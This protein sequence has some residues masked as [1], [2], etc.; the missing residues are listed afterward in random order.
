MRLTRAV[1]L[2]AALA[3]PGLAAARL[4]DGG[5]DP[6]RVVRDAHAALRAGRHA[7]A[8][9]RYIEAA[10]GVPDIS[11]W[12]LRRAALLTPD[13]AGRAALYSQIR[14]PIVRARLLETEALARERNGDHRGAAIRYDS[15][16]RLVDATR[17]RLL[18]APGKE[19]RRG[20]RLGLVTYIDRYAGSLQAQAAIDLLLSTDLELT[21]ED[22]LTVARA[23]ARARLAAQ[24]V[25]LYPR[26]IA[27]GL[28]TPQ[29]RIAYGLA[30][31]QLGRHRDAIAAF[32]KVPADAPPAREA[33]YQRAVSLSR[34]GLGDS[35]VAVLRRVAITEDSDDVVAPK[36]LFLIGDIRWR[37]GDT[38][39]ARASWREQVRKYPRHV[40]TGR[41]GFLAAMVLWESGRVREAAAEWEHI[42]LLNGSTDGLATGYW[43]GRS[44]EQLG[45]TA[46][47]RGLWQSVMARDSL[48][49]YAVASARRLGVA[50]WAPA[51]APDRF[52]SYPDLDSVATR[53]KLLRALDMT[54]ELG[55]ERTQLLTEIAPSP[56]RLLAA[57]DMLRRDGQ[58]SAAI[59]L[60]RRALQAGA[61][62]DARTYRLI[63][64]LLHADEIRQQ[65]QTN[66]LDPVVVAALIRQESAWEPK[67]RSRAGA[68]GLMQVMPATGRQIAQTL[69]V[70]R[71]NTDL[72]LDP[73]MNIR[74]GTHYFGAALR[75]FEGDLTRALAAYNAGAG[76]VGGWAKGG[77]A[78]DPELFV[79]RISFVET[80]DY[81]RIVQRNLALYRALYGA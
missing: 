27:A 28:A 81:V 41:A 17:V 60:G 57:A 5:A 65:S 69:G 7:E 45:E 42:H 53:L 68:L 2:L 29:D 63:Y 49:Y 66:G 51:A 26:T 71:W 9:R 24:T 8:R 43:A 20:L 62:A 6:E 61:R 38:T 54:D 32:M 75:K 64:P 79:E 73:V 30:L 1:V 4:P 35:A 13:S 12:L 56:E 58:P 21:P 16:G 40:D 44:Y 11:D 47:A 76:R 33:A 50:S 36:A 59:A 70:T 22:A 14:L 18:T 52:R 37:A 34:L 77:A 78:T 80:R 48:S 74:F 46:H 3:F 72:L 31:A 55:W 19:E 39:G 10:A 15:L 67:A 23:A 25:R